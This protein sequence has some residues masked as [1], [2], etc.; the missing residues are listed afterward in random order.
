MGR[1]QANLFANKVRVYQRSRTGSTTI[2]PVRR[3][4]RPLSWRGWDRPSRPCGGSAAA[5]GEAAFN[6]GL[7]A[8]Q[9][10]L[11]RSLG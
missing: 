8:R 11:K 10:D 1:A 6:L 3:S 4:A 5:C 7:G 9:K 2:A